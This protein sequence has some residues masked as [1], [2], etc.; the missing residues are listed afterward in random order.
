[1]EMGGVDGNKEDISELCR[2][3]FKFL[4]TKQGCRV[5]AGRRRG[6]TTG[7][8]RRV[9]LRGA[10]LPFARHFGRGSGPFTQDEAESKSWP[11]LR[12]ACKGRNVLD[13]GNISWE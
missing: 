5:V 2:D 10:L 6:P 9:G 13:N 1:M 8:G 3:L 7:G 11:S 12:V 4:L